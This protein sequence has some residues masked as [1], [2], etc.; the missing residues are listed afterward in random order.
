MHLLFHSAQQGSSSA[1]SVSSLL[2]YAHLLHLGSHFLNGIV[3]LSFET[4]NSSSFLLVEFF[5]G[6]SCP[7]YLERFI[8]SYP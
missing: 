1:D 6:S 5:P 4:P 3:T 8:E 2:E 7:D